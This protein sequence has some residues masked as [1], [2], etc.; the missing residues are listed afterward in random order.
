MLSPP[1]R[2]PGPP[3]EDPNP[4]GVVAIVSSGGF[5]LLLSADAESEALLPLRL[6]DVDAM[7]VPHH[8]SSDPGLPE[9]LARLRPELAAIEVGANTYGHPAPSTLAALR[10]AR[11][12]TYRTDRHGTVTLTVD[13]RRRARGAPS[14]DPAR[15]SLRLHCAGGRPEARL[16]RLRR[17]RREDRRLAPAPA[18]ARRG[19]ARP[20][21]PRDLRRPHDRARRG[22]H[23]AGQPDLRPGRALPARG[24]RGRVEGRPARPARGGPG[25][26]AAGHRARPD[27]SRQ[28]AQGAARRGRRRPAATCATARRRSRG[29]CPSGRWSGAASSGLQLDRRGAPRSSWRGWARASSGSRASS[30]SCDRPSS[31]RQRRGRGRGAPDRGRHRPAGLRPRRRPRGGRPARHARARRGARVARRARRQARVPGRPA[32]ARGAPRRGAARVRHGR[33]RRW[34]GALGGPPWLAKKTIARARK[35]DRE[36]LEHA[37]EVFSELEVDLRGGG[38]LQLDEDT[39][40]SL[41]LARATA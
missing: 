33:S 36:T 10:R 2:P 3:P 28:A 29:S 31:L 24:R 20:G 39:A 30:R 19:G 17:R 4:R 41:A 13:E 12:P 16:P 34:P 6:P 21:R 25:R 32:A 37:L 11:V 8:G 9:V 40:F 15:P 23:G 14:T 38:E 35:A 7:K 5:R 26:P 1:P 22:G 18:A 27:R